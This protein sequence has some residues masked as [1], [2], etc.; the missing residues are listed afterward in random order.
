VIHGDEENARAVLELHIEVYEGIAY[1]IESH[2][3]NVAINGGEIDPNRMFSR[4]GAEANLKSLNP[5]WDQTRIAAALAVLD[6]G[7]ERLVQAFFPP[8]GG[9]LVALHNNSEAYSVADERPIS[10]AESIRDPDH[11]H[12]F[13]LCTDP[14]DFKILA[15]SPYN[16]V[17]QQHGPRED[18]GSLSRLAAARGVRYVNLEVQQGQQSRQQEMVDWLERHLPETPGPAPA[19]ATYTK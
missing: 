11:P 2:T 17:L 15:T 12:A 6:R 3:R 4:T 1:I 10:D 19:I 14:S 9:L 18:D 13:F 7:R 16:V 5:S 8:P